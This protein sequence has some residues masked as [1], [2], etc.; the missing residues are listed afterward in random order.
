VN[1]TRLLAA[2]IGGHRWRAAGR[3]V[4]A[5]RRRPTEQTAIVQ[6]ASVARKC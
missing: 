6:A 1:N 3:N 4:R 2:P 5:G